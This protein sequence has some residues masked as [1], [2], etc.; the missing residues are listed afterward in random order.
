MKRIDDFL[1]FLENN[2]RLI[3]TTDE[4][5]TVVT[6]KELMKLLGKENFNIITIDDGN[7]KIC[8]NC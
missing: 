4:Y 3:L 7:R 2:N 1:I 8:F 5:K 6:P